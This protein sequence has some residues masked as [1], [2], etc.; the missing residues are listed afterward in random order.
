MFVQRLDEVVN[1]NANIPNRSSVQEKKTDEG[2]CV[3]DVES[4]VDYESGVDERVP[5]E[6]LRLQ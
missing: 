5:N 4:F 6:T 2:V 1:I 3:N